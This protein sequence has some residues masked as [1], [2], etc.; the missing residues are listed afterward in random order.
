MFPYPPV[1]AL[2]VS[3]LWR[4]TLRDS[5]NDSG[6]DPRDRAFEYLTDGA[7]ALQALCGRRFDEYIATIQHDCIH[8][9][10]NGDVDGRTLFL[11]GDLKTLTSIDSGG[12]AI[13]TNSVLLEPRG[14]S[15][16]RMIIIT[17]TA[18]YW[19]WGDQNVPEAAIDIVGVWGY[20]GAWVLQGQTLGAALSNTTGTALTVTAASAGVYGLERGGLIKIDS[21][22][23]FIDGGSGTALTVQRGFNGSTAAT[24]LNGAAIYRFMFDP[25]VR[26][27]TNRIVKWMQEQDKS[28]LFGTAMIGETAIPL[29]VDALPRDVK[30]LADSSG[31]RR[32]PPIL[33]WG[34]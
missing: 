30:E 13:P 11:R 34:N 8:I 10:H 32:K 25:I 9:K 5:S 22:Y 26:Q 21:E 24:H 4:T 2:T 33:V 15:S 31:V 27:L 28:P 3:E 29:I 18:Y 20:G 19:Q 12:Q 7:A 17:D 16:K 14:Y 6:N 1:P 23:M